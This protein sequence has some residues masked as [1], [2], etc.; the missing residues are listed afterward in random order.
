MKYPTLPIT[1]QPRN[2][3]FMKLSIARRNSW[4]VAAQL[5]VSLAVLL[6]AGA[7]HARPD[8]TPL[9]P[10]IADK[11]SAYYHFSVRNFDSADGRRHYRVWTG[12]PDTPPPASGFPILYMLDGNAVMDRLTDELLQKLSKS[13]PPVLVA[14]G[15]QTRL[16]F[17][18]EARAYDYIAPDDANGSHQGDSDRFG[19]KGGGGTVFLDLIENRIIPESEHNLKL[20]PAR[21]GIWGHSYGGLFVLNAY[22]SSAA[23]HYFYA[24]SP[25]VERD[26]FAALDRLGAIDRKNYCAKY[27]EIAEGDGDPKKRDAAKS[28][29]VLGR[30]KSTLSALHAGG[31]PATYSLY[32]GLK[33]GQTFSVSLQST[34]LDMAGLPH[35]NTVKAPSADCSS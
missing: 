18:Q 28:P 30:V 8:L 17:D 31:L 2:N 12:I 33:H 24:V 6:H 15:Y 3:A 14:I 23:F 9:G 29:D 1:V 4:F 19:R 25:S 7:S 35:P 11:G 27:L 21:R 26:H 22:L 5:A 10:N 20:N 34:L 13:T 32:P 16:P